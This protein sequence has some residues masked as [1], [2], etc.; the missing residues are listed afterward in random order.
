VRLL[1]FQK[2][3]FGSKFLAHFHFLWKV[4]ALFAVGFQVSGLKNICF[5]GLGLAAWDRPLSH[6]KINPLLKS[7]P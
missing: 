6:L 7:Y 5:E 3:S 1:V 2:K 4:V